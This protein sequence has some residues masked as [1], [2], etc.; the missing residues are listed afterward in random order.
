MSTNQILFYARHLNQTETMELGVK[1]KKRKPSS[2]PP[3]KQKK[4]NKGKYINS[5]ARYFS[6]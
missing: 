1:C 4:M 5:N 3:P 2:P 6:V